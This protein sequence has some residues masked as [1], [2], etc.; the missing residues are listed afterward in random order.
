[1]GKL[2]WL[3]RV[4]RS[5]ISTCLC[6]DRVLKD[7]IFIFITYE[8][9]FTCSRMREG[10]QDKWI[11]SFYSY[12]ISLHQEVIGRISGQSEFA[13]RGAELLEFKRIRLRESERRN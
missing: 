3:S 7:S 10:Y 1:M 12:Y 11:D 6:F 2:L 5:R 8:E 4:S 13:C 9:W